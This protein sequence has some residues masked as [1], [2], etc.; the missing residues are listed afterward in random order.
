LAPD[1]ALLIRRL[2]AIRRIFVDDPALG[3]F[4]DSEIRVADL[5][6]LGVCT[7]RTVFCS[8]ANAFHYTSIVAAIVSLSGERVWRLTAYFP[9]VLTKVVDPHARPAHRDWS[10]PKALAGSHALAR[11]SASVQA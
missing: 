7:E 6:R 5:L 4:I 2:A 3:S 11:S 9:L 1:S 10:T 8:F